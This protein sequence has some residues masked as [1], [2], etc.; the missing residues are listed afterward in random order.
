[1]NTIEARSHESVRRLPVL[2]GAAAC[3][4]HRIAA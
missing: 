1:M 4:V 2:Q 3:R